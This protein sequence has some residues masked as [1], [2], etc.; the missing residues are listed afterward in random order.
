MMDIKSMFDKVIEFVKK[1]FNKL[2]HRVQNLP[3]DHITQ[4]IAPVIRKVMLVVYDPTIPSEGGK[5]LSAVMGWNDVK[6]L[7]SGYI[8]DLSK[9][10]NG[11]VHYE[12]A[13]R[14][15]LDHFP[16]KQD[17]F[18]YQS[19]QFVGYLRSG[20][21]ANFHQPDLTNYMAIVESYD[22]I[23]RI[24]RAEIDEV[25]L[26]GFPYSGF[27]ESCMAGPGA[28]WCNGPELKE[29]G[30]SSRRFVIMGFNFER[31]VGEML[32]AF[33]HRCESIMKYVYRKHSGEANLYERFIR[34]DQVNPGKAEVGTVHF[35]PNSVRD[36]D[37]GNRTRVLSFCRNWEKFPDLSG[38]AVQVDCSEWGNGDIRLHHQ[39]WLKHM[40]HLSGEF[41]GIAYNWWQYVVDP[42]T[43]K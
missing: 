29:T 8:E 37:W 33:S 17:G 14:F 39:W 35:S 31:G 25:W 24:D 32:E 42:N 19:D 4:P 7:T 41:Q 20:D 11:Y 18:A 34:Y 16:V 22:L 12:V 6:D 2:F 15:D 23:G 13:L 30:H 38:P 21:S 36:Y 43:V 28:F 26:F 40:P 10:S 5:R 3:D 9:V 1:E 27:Y